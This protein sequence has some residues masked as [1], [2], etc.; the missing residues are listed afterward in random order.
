SS[1]Q[2][3]VLMGEYERASQAAGRARE[4]FQSLGDER[5][6][7]RLDINIANLY[8]RQDR[9]PE[10]LASYRSAYEKLL[11]YK[12]AEAI[13][14]ALHNMAVCLIMLDDFQAAL[15]TF[16]DAQKICE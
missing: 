9:F 12:D 3:L 6:L 11:P 10:A 7:A 2:A 13:G 8:H 14:V 15:D 5:R 16:R 4:I 1:I